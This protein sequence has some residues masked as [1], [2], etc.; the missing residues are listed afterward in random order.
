M[1]RPG[2]VPQRLL[3]PGLGPGRLGGRRG[4]RDPEGGR[5]DRGGEGKEP[6]RGVGV[7]IWGRRGGEAI[8]EPG[9]VRP[10]AEGTESGG[11]VRREG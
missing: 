4:A 5:G 7:G 1:E 8:M 6:R 2:A 3:R 9:G 11:S 10:G